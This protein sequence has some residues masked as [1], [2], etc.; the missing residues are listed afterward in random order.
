MCMYVFPL[1]NN[2]GLDYRGR[3]EEIFTS[4]VPIKNS[5]GSAYTKTGNVNVNKWSR[6]VQNVL[7]T[8]KEQMDTA[9]SVHAYPNHHQIYVLAFA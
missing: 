3:E 9:A 1:T 2:I 4:A 5:Q 8:S 7:T 6:C